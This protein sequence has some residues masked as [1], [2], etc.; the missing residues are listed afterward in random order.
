[1]KSLLFVLLFFVVGCNP[2]IVAEVEEGIT[3][4]EEAEEVI[5]EVEKESE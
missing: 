3:I 2:A 5:E 4:A 1:M